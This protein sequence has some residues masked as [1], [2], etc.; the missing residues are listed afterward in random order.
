MNGT[1][2]GNHKIEAVLFI[3]KSKRGIKAQNNLYIRNFPKAWP[4]AKIEEFIQTAFG[5]Y[6]EI[7]S[8]GIHFSNKA[9][10]F[11]AFVCF[12]DSSNAQK[13]LVD[14]EHHEIEDQKL[15]LNFA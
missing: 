7:T 12:A 15:Y 14:F 5:E 8:K 9:N 2:V 10:S 11:Y 4:Q 6:G 13:I 1:V 3:P